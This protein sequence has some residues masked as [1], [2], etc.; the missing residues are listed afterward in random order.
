MRILYIGG[1]FVGACSSAVSADSG[2][3]TLVFDIEEE[4]VKKLSIDDREVIESC[5]HEQGLG[6]LLIRNRSRLKFTSMLSDIQVFTKEAVDVVFMCLPTP[7][8]K[9][10]SGETDLSYY[11]AAVEMIGPL[12]AAR[13]GGNSAN[14]LVIVNK[15]TVPIRMIDYTKELFEKQGIANFGIVSNPEFLVEGKAIENSIHPDRVVVGAENEEDFSIMRKVYQRFYD[16][17]SVTYLEVNP[18]EAACSKLLANFL[19]FN[20]VVTAYDV[21]GRVCEYFPR[22]NYEQIRKILLTDPRIGSWGLYDSLFCG[23]SCF[24]KDAGS[25][26]HQLEQAGSHATLIRSILEANVFQRDHFFGR[27][28]TEAGIQW[29][30]KVVAVLGVAFKQNTNDIRNS[31]AI[32]IIH[33]LLGAG[34]ARINIYDPAAMAECQKYFATDKNDLYTRIHYVQ[35]E[36][37]ALLGT[38]VA[39]LCT[40]WPQFKGLTPAILKTVQPPYTIMDGRRLLQADFNELSQRGYNIISVG[41]AFIKGSRV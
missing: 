2:H 9:D 14:R 39:I 21:V 7:E 28:E 1:G 35:N 32:A 17:T 4:K 18:Y 10:A 11:E 34:V 29:S 24:I 36:T 40:D 19:L 5:I 6:E 20:R 25:L 31:G 8:K 23:G 12:L 30:N 33:Q 3:E 15:S 27:A 26:A 41:S 37:E 22:V 38:E 13:N 16:S